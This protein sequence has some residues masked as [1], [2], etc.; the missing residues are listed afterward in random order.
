MKIEAF[1]RHPSYLFIRA[2]TVVIELKLLH[3]KVT[4]RT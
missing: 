3:L 2:E 1:G 4:T